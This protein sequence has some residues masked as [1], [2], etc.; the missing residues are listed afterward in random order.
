M[1]R[2][3]E[4]SHEIIMMPNVNDLKNNIVEINKLYYSYVLENN[5]LDITLINYPI[6]KVIKALFNGFVTTDKFGNILDIT[7]DDDN[8]GYSRIDAFSLVE[9]IKISFDVVENSGFKGFINFK[10][11]KID[12][13]IFNKEEL[14]NMYINVPVI[15]ECNIEVV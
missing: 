1:K 14:L 3:E 11:D 5:I 8:C 13:F 7:G 2:F 10:I 9:P 6:Y 4:G 12:Q 15:E